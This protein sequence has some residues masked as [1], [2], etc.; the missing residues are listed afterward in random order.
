MSAIDL[1]RVTYMTT[2]TAKASTQS[3]DYFSAKYLNIKNVL[4]VSQIYT[5]N[6]SDYANAPG[7]AFQFYGDTGYWW[8]ICLYNGI[9]DP[10]TGFQPGDTINLPSLADINA[11]LSNQDEQL[12]A[13]TTVT[14]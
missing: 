3:L 12:L 11:L 2:S 6:L 13:T 10:I 1:R 5:L 8:V 14:I 9:I 7:L 4:P